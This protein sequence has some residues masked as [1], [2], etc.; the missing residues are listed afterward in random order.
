MLRLS[1]A[2]CRGCLQEKEV[3]STDPDKPQE[4]AQLTQIPVARHAKI[5]EG[6]P[7]N[8]FRPHG[9]Q[10][11]P[12]AVPQLGAVAFVAGHLALR[13]GHRC[14]AAPSERH[15]GSG[16][17]VFVDRPWVGRGSKSRTLRGSHEGTSEAGWFQG[18]ADPLPNIDGRT[19]DA[20]ISIHNLGGIYNLLK[21]DD[22]R[23]SCLASE[24]HLSPCPLVSA[25]P[26]L[27]CLV[28]AARG[29]SFSSRA[30]NRP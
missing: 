29:C 6:Y 30:C 12:V 19:V 9:L 1:L 8:S 23:S 10:V 22:W 14:G 25:C 20:S 24:W 26:L 11:K 7:I 16:S 2:F 4:P 21:V 17:T 5:Q 27:A 3:P 13:P 18:S 15:R 28:S